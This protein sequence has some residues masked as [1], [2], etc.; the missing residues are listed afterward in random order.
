MAPRG[1]KPK[2]AALRRAEG[3]P[4]KRK[5]HETPEPRQIR[6]DRPT[7]LDALAGTVWDRLVPELERTGVLTIVDG[8]A[9]A[10]TCQSYSDAVA[11][12]A[13]LAKQ[14]RQSWKDIQA[15]QHGVKTFKAFATEFGLTPS[16]RSRIHL[17][18]PDDD[19]SEGLD[20]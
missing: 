3:N 19:D 14:K 17:P 2:P 10:I 11:A 8:D 6:P 9:L 18:E 5:I 12:R 4:G 1:R 7:W 16:S 15:W 13:R 20:G